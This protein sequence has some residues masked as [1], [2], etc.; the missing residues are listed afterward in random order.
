LCRVPIKLDAHSV[1][2]SINFQNKITKIDNVRV[3]GYYL[4]FPLE[5]Q[6]LNVVR[7]NILTIIHK[8]GDEII[9]DKHY[10]RSK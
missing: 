2:Q 10:I 3:V 1:K 7:A 9:I 8:Q 4:S 6:K 5:A